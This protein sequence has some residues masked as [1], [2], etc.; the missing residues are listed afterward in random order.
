MQ[1]TLKDK[2]LRIIAN[3]SE[4]PNEERIA[5]IKDWITKRAGLTDSDITDLEKALSNQFERSSSKGFSRRALWVLTFL[6]LAKLGILKTKRSN[7]Y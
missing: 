4:V 3:I 5:E 7:Y 2:A 6:G 1:E